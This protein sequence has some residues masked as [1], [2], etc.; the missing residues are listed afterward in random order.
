MIDLTPE[1]LTIVRRI[2]SDTAVGYEVWAFGSRVNGRAVKNSDLDLAVVSKEKIEWRR[3]ER[4]KDAFS[5]SDLPFMVDV[6]DFSSLD[7][8]LAKMITAT[9]EVLVPRAV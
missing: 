3:I 8:G 9:H 2:L 1:Q 6:V 5:A 7:E 4:I